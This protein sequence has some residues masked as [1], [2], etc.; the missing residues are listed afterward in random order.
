M[1][2]IRFLTYSYF[3]YWG[4]CYLK[5]GDFINPM[6]RLEGYECCILLLLGLQMWAIHPDWM[7]GLFLQIEGMYH[8]Q[9][10]IVMLLLCPWTILQLRA[11]CTYDRPGELY[12][13]QQYFSP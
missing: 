13:P 7:D 10:Y 3:I 4:Q 11:S 8:D 5:C 6:G 2:H 12:I 9:R 1:E